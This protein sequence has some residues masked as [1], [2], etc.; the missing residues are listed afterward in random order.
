MKRW[1]YRPRESGF[2]LCDVPILSGALKALMAW[3]HGPSV[4]ALGT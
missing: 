4:A 2:A 1:E 3:R